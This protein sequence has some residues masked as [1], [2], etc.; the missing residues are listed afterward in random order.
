MGETKRREVTKK[1]QEREEQSEDR[2][3]LERD[4]GTHAIYKELEDQVLRDPN[5][6]GLHRGFSATIYA[7]NAALMSLMHP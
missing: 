5:N 7:G 3:S 6:P 1:E 2:N 4:Q